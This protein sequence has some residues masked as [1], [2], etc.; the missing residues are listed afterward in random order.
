MLE[1]RTKWFTN[2]LAKESILKND[3]IMCENGT[4][5]F[6]VGYGSLTSSGKN[7]YNYE[8]K[9]AKGVLLASG[10]SAYLDKLTTIIKGENPKTKERKESKQSETNKPN[11]KLIGYKDTL[12]Y[13]SFL[14]QEKKLAKAILDMNTWYEEN[15][16]S[17]KQDVVNLAK[18]HA[19]IFNRDTR[20]TNEAKLERVKTMRRYYKGNEA[21]KNTYKYLCELW[22][23]LD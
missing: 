2:S 19:S 7:T 14:A 21:H 16:C 6:I 8:L 18:L 15:G 12:V 10:K 22:N 17:S 1:L 20:R 13:K 3:F 4:H 23:D 11:N 9:D 5:L